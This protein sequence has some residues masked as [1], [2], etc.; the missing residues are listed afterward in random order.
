ML[1]MKDRVGAS[2]L[3][4]A[5]WLMYA[6]LLWSLKAAM[7]VFY[8]R[9]TVSTLSGWIE[10]CF[11]S[12][13]R[14]PPPF[15]G[16]DGGVFIFTLLY[17]IIRMLTATQDSLAGYRSRIYLFFAL[18]VTTFGVAFAVPF[19]T[20]IPITNMWQIDPDPGRE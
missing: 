18:M 11:L 5:G 20:C 10:I 12:I 16:A 13:F 6:L 9:L 15:S 17:V 14:A 3:R 19:I 8:L 1:T 7:A 2:K 4:L